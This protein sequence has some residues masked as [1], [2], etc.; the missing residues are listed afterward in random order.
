MEEGASLYE[1]K[2]PE[3]NEEKFHYSVFIYLCVKQVLLSKT[4]VYIGSIVTPYE[5]FFKHQNLFFQIKTFHDLALLKSKWMFPL[6]CPEE[7][8]KYSF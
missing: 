3:Y 6:I 2:H 1:F 4:E 8:S 5:N 7:G